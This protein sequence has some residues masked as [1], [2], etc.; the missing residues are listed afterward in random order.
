MPAVDTIEG[1]AHHDARGPRWKQLHA[2]EYT[3][4]AATAAP[5]A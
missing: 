3:P 4:R 5:V 1:T 2:Y